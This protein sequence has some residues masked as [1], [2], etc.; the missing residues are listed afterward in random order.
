MELFSSAYPVEVK[1]DAR[2]FRTSQP[3]FNG[4]IDECAPS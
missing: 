3:I 2:E 1:G 4:R